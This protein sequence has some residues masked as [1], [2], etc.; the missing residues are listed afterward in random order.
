LSYTHSFDNYVNSSKL[1]SNKNLHFL[2]KYSI[3]LIHTSLFYFHRARVKGGMKILGASASSDE[4][5]ISIENENSKHTVARV[6]AFR[7]DQ[8]PDSTSKQQD[9]A[10]GN[11]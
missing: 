11:K 9:D 6:T 7:K 1:K 3:F 10:N 8:D 2:T 4:W 5:N